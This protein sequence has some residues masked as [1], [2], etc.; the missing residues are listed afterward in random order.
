MYFDKHKYLSSDILI[1]DQIKVIFHSR[2][3]KYN[4]LS[5]PGAQE[6]D[7]VCS[8]WAELTSF[9]WLPGLQLQT[10]LYK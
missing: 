7:A 8:L 3:K 5:V 2:I 9:L 10:L 1:Y 4:L 6:S